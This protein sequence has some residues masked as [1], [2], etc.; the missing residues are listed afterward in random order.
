MSEKMNQFIDSIIYQE[1]SLLTQLEQIRG[2]KEDIKTQITKEAASLL[3]REYLG[4]TGSKLAR[5]IVEQSQ[6][7]QV[8]LL[9]NSVNIQ[10][11][12]II[13]RLRTFL[14]TVSE[15][16]SGLKEP[17]SNRLLSRLEK[18]QEGVR[19]STRINAT[20]RLLISLKSKHLVYNSEIPI[21]SPKQAVFPP[22]SS[23]RGLVELNNVFQSVTGYVKI[24]DPWADIKT[25]ELFLSIPNNV[26]I[27]FLTE[28]LGGKSKTRRLKRACMEFQVE[29]PS[30][31]VRKCEGLHD[32]FILSE[33]Q[34]WSVGSSIKDFGKNFSALTPLSDVVKKETEIIF[35][36]LWKKGNSVV[37]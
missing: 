36:G 11:I 1:E 13:S 8:K 32:R 5:S 9:N 31:E 20:I 26:P 16:K 2:K 27:Q 35:N 6:K 10:H 3:A 37:P 23:F 15:W 25:L 18:A 30:F 21:M 22:G 12:S 24:C 19:V 7:E 28:N 14:S 34:G 4:R 17:N 33:K 29:H